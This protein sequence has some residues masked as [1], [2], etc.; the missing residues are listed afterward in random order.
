MMYADVT[1]MMVAATLASRSKCNERKV[2][3]VLVYDDKAGMPMIVS[4]GIN[5]TKP[6]LPN[7]DTNPTHA[8]QNCLDKIAG[9]MPMLDLSRCTL[10]VT[11]RP[12]VSCTAVLI[13]KNIGRVVYRDSQP[14]MGHIKD[15]ME[16][17]EVSQLE[18][19]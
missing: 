18:V 4:E 11:C 2:G 14:E 7:D 8:E 13:R 16:V 19:K 6:G 17:C 3:C 15:L 5:G 9:W 1:Y 12:C 10:Y